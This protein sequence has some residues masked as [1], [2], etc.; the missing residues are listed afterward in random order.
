MKEVALWEFVGYRLNIAYYVLRKPSKY[1]IRNTQYIVNPLR[2][3]RATIVFTRSQTGV[4][5]RVNK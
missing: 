5:E 2:S 3:K 4:W 1:A